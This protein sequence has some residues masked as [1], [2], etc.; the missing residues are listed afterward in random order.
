[1]EASEDRQLKYI[2]LLANEKAIDPDSMKNYLKKTL[3]KDSAKY[4]TKDEASNLI[5]ILKNIP[6]G[7]HV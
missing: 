2:H 6:E 1:M 5:E 7:D 3:N 4:L